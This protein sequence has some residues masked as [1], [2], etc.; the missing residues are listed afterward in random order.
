M[1][2]FFLLETDVGA[3][4]AGGLDVV[5]FDLLDL[6]GPGGRLLGLGSVGREATDESFELRDLTLVLL[7]LL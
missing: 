2:L 3:N 4:A 1:Q 6:P 7:F 5:Q